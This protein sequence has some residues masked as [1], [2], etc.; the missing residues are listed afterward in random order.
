M[1]KKVDFVDASRNQMKL[2]IIGKVSEVDDARLLVL[3]AELLQVDLS[4]YEAIV[5][6]SRSENMDRSTEIDTPKVLAENISRTTEKPIRP[7]LQDSYGSNDVEVSLEEELT[8][9]TK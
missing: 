3:V 6:E 8:Y 2:D 1:T 5:N 4:E 9:L 7:F